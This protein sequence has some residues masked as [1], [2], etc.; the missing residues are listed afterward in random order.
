M[1]QLSAQRSEAEALA[2]YKSLQAKYPSELGDRPALVRRADLG[3]KG[4]YYRTLVGPF[5]S[6]ADA[7]QFCGSLKA[8]GGQCLIL[9]N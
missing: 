3:P 6:T 4:I 8:A 7:D 1:V 5:G 9:K 2:A